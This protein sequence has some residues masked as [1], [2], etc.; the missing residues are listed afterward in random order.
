MMQVKIMLRLLLIIVISLLM[1]HNKKV[2]D[3][4]DNHL[5]VISKNESINIGYQY[6]Q[7]D[8][9]WIRFSPGGINH[10]MGM[11]DITTSPRKQVITTSMFNKVKKTQLFNSCTDWIGPYIV[12]KGFETST[13]NPQF[14]G[15]WHGS[16]MNNEEPTARMINYSINVED[17]QSDDNIK[18]ATYVKLKVKNNIQAYNT[19]DTKEEVLEET[20]TYDISKGT[21]GVQVVI[22][23]LEDCVIERYYGLQ[24]Q[25]TLYD[26]HVLY[27]GSG[28]GVFGSYAY[29]E[30]LPKT[31]QCMNLITLYS[32]DGRHILEAYLD[33]QYGLA[34]GEYVSD[35][36]PYAFT[37]SYGKT[38]F[39]L[40]NGKELY[41]EKG[42]SVVWR[43]KYTFKYKE[44]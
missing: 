12:R 37:L 28:D 5:W 9:L 26:G 30:S 33:N 23:A 18:K 27:E 3:I 39:N 36:K 44:E 10:I 20:V 24:T 41:L 7:L 13:Y 16:E 42:E 2:D 38:Y 25:N 11:A 17:I 21:I 19:L 32:S 14:T 35:S 29:S 4:S 43:G 40:V 6:N 34:N 15:G 8:N 31:T 22:N 1:T